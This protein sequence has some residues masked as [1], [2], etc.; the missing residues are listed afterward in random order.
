MYSFRAR[1]LSYFQTQW[2]QSW[3]KHPHYNTLTGTHPLAIQVLRIHFVNFISSDTLSTYSIFWR[4]TSSLSN[5]YLNHFTTS[6]LS[7]ALLILWSP[8]WAIAVSDCFSR[9]DHCHLHS[10]GLSQILTTTSW[11]CHKSK[12]G[13]ERRSPSAENAYIM[14][15]YT[16]T[17]TQKKR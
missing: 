7:L 2:S 3:W 17:R 16:A 12:V 5:F 10:P 1:R 15:T 8:R 4:P 9:E 6:F 13:S 14:K 11:P